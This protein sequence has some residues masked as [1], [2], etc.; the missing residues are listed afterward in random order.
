M[1]NT[2]FNSNLA[3]EVVKPHLNERNIKII[4]IDFDVLVNE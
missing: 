4:E 3:D 2:N 1:K